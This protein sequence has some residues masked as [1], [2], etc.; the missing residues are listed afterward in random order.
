M[1]PKKIIKPKQPNLLEEESLKLV[2][3]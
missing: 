1:R 3:L 2:K